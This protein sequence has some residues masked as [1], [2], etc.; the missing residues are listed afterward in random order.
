VKLREGDTSGLVLF[1][2]ELA[3]ARG[4]AGLTQEDLAHRLSYS[5]SL[6]A[7]VE[8]RRRAPTLDFAQRCDQVF[9]LPGTFARLQQFARSTPVP[10]WFRPWAEIEA[11]A[12]QLRLFEHSLIPGLLQ[13]QDYAKAVLSTRPAT[14]ETE[15]AELVTARMDRQAILYRNDPPMVLAIIDEAAFHR[16]IGSVK[17]MHE[18]TTHLW[19]MAD[20]PNVI[21]QV[22][23][24]A[25]GAHCG[26]VGA[27]AIAAEADGSP[28]AAY[29]ESATEGFIGETPA[30]LAEICSAF[31]TL[32]AEA[33]PRG[34][35]KGMIMKWA[36][37]YERPE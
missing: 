11:T 4:K 5:P 33:L 24:L 3:A 13:T 17:T 8:G 15:V 25:A 31:D 9:G 16:P 30:V 32:R 20:R 2:A 26:L 34:A 21:V 1:S 10:A 27:F 7:M 37:E 22:I 12:A 18:Q 6:I 14:T 29:L 28:R 36:E 23:P 35:S 19:G